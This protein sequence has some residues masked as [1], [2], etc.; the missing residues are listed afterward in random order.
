MSTYISYLAQAYF[1]QDFDLDAET[2]LGVVEMFRDSESADTV[3]ALRAEIVTLLESEP[4]EE[5]LANV[6]LDE[7]GAEYDPRLGGV[8]VRNWL[9]RMAE[10]LATEK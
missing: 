5:A 7:A 3:E 6:W 1:H 9:R 10:T 2:P 8:T 4:T